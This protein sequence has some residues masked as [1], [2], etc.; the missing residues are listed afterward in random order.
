MLS[1]PAIDRRT[2]KRQENW[3]MFRIVTI[4]DQK[5]PQSATVVNGMLNSKHAVVALFERIPPKRTKKKTHF[6]QL[7]E[8]DSPRAGLIWPTSHAFFP[9]NH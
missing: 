7:P 6:Q 8:T 3:T 9:Y 2:K 5:R 1:H 4:K